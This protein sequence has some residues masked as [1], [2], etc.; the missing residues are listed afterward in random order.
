M[1]LLLAQRNECVPNASIRLLSLGLGK[2]R[3]KHVGPKLQNSALDS[4][5][6]GV[7]LGDFLAPPRN[8]RILQQLLLFLGLQICRENVNL[9]YGGP[10]GGKVLVCGWV[11]KETLR[12]SLSATNVSMN[13]GTNSQ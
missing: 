12:I 1:S 6:L 9:F 11:A 10:S 8:V 7:F 3:E 5:S 2:C 4:R 13:Q